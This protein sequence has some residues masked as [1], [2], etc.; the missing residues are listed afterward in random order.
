MAAASALLNWM[1]PAALET[2]PGR[3]ADLIATWGGFLAATT[4]LIVLLVTML[5]QIYQNLQA[6]GR[7]LRRPRDPGN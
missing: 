4:L 2:T 1:G 6:I 3:P 5:R 7:A